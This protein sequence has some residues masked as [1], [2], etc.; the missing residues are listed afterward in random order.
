MMK[1]WNNLHCVGNKSGTFQLK[2]AV[3]MFSAYMQEAN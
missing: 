3:E 2:N 1:K